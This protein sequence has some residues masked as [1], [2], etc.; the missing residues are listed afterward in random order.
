MI[1]F[2]LKQ[3]SKVGQVY[4]SLKSASF[5]LLTIKRTQGDQ[6]SC[7]CLY[8]RQLKLDKIDV[9]LNVSA[10]NTVTFRYPVMNDLVYGY[11]QGLEPYFSASLLS[12]SCFTLF[13]GRKRASSGQDSSNLELSSISDAYPFMEIICRTGFLYYFHYSAMICNTVKKRIKC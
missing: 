4:F 10:S 8:G 7:S 11:T 9:T 3:R 2:I 12:C 5:S 13:S 1:H 6:L